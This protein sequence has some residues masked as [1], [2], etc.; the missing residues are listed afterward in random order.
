MS[1]LFIVCDVLIC[2]KLHRH[3]AP[4]TRIIVT[5]KTILFNRLKHVIRCDVKTFMIQLLGHTFQIFYQSYYIMYN[6]KNG[7]TMKN[8]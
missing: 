5:T 2:V 6:K 1:F 8:Q 7:A 4:K 3:S